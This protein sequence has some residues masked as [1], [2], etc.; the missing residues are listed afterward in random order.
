[1]GLDL[2]MKK[3]RGGETKKASDKRD[4]GKG[5]GKKLGEVSDEL[6]VGGRKG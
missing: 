1:L 6:K 4:D 2:P 5:G 3:G